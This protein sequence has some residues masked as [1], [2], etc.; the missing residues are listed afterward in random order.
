[1]IALARVT[2][3]PPSLQDLVILCSAPIKFY[4]AL[5]SI[6]KILVLEH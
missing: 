6:E 2:V 4:Y 5:S 1:M 3:L